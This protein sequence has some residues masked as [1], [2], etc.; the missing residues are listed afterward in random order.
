MLLSQNNFLDVI[1]DNLENIKTRYKVKSI[2][3]FGS[4]A[5]NL[6]TLASDV[7][8]LVEFEDGF[9]TF[10]NYMDLKFYLENIYQKKVDLVMR[11]A[12][13]NPRIKS[14]ILSEVKYA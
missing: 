6:G 5:N 8:I 14:R 12:P 11:D 10:D 13:I 9:E 3:L 1:H 4:F 7:D 2:G